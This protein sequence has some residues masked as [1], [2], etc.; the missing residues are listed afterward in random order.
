MVH[1]HQ[2]RAAVVG[3]VER[4]KEGASEEALL[5]KIRQQISKKFGGK[6]GAVVEGNLAVMKEGLAATQRVDY[7]SPEFRVT[8]GDA[9]FEGRML[10]AFVA[11]AQ[12][13]GNR[14]HVAPTARMDDG[15]L[16]VLG[17]GDRGL[18][19]HADRIAEQAPRERLDR[20]GDRRREEHRL[21][22]GRQ[23]VDGRVLAPRAEHDAEV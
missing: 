22:L 8:A 13:C 7:E 18:D 17:G 21:P 3:H 9:R 5:K 4:I 2:V 19:R 23:L 20:R 16:D 1:P 10:L 15:L 14:M 6:G 11:N 12:Y